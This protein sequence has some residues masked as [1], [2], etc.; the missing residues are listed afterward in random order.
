MNLSSSNDVLIIPVLMIISQKLPG[1]L[2]EKD[3]LLCILWL[4]CSNVYDVDM[5][6]C[7]YLCQYICWVKDSMP[8]PIF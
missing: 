3:V 2:S 6:V 5:S 4:D 7:C 8:I 1:K